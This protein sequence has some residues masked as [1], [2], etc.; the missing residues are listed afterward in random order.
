MIAALLLLLAASPRV[1]LV[2]KAFEIPARQWRY[3]DHSLSTEPAL[4][5]CQFESERPDTRVRV[6]LVSRRELDAWLSGRDHDEI[7]STPVGPSG[8]L[9]VAAHD[10]ETYVVIENLGPRPASVHLR[11]FLDEAAV[12][13]LSRG[14]RLAVVAI[15]IGVFFAIVSLSARKLLKAIKPGP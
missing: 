13:Y 1:L 3:W 10:P 9:E 2:D 11:V 8:M 5:S 12:R 7:G 6:A 4:L 15:S 14:R